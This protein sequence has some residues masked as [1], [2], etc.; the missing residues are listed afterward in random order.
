MGPKQRPV[1]N[2][3][4]RCTSSRPKGFMGMRFSKRIAPCHADSAPRF[5]FFTKSSRRGRNCLWMTNVYDQLEVIYVKICVFLGWTWG[6]EWSVRAPLMLWVGHA[7]KAQ[8]PHSA[9][10]ALEPTVQTPVLLQRRPGTW[11]A[12]GE[13]RAQAAAGH[14]QGEGPW[15]LLP[16]PACG[17]GG[18][19]P[20]KAD[21][22]RHWHLGPT[23]AAPL[24]CCRSR[25]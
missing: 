14:S 6:A 20:G 23:H 4:V 1:I 9:R 24:L 2:L 18:R 25:R 5:G 3:F 21:Q 12:D 19:W 13:A 11:E 7:Q 15:P 10:S 22:C 8:L 16:W 17:V